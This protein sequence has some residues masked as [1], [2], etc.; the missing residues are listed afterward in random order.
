MIKEC[1]CHSQVTSSKKESEILKRSIASLE[2]QISTKENDN[3]DLRTQITQL[4]EELDFK[5]LILS[6]NEPDI[7]MSRN[8]VRLDL[9][10]M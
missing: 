5:V 6:Y 8:G 7:E 3:C 9:D 1:P 4:K 10:K 2:E